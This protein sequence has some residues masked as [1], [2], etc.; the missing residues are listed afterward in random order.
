MYT[1]IGSDTNNKAL[2][3]KKDRK[4]E[5]ENEALRIHTLSA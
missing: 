4:I 1:T 2:G 5:K 3:N